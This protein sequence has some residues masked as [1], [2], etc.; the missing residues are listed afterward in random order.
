MAAA[1]FHLEYAWRSRVWYSQLLVG[2][3]PAYGI[4]NGSVAF[5]PAINDKLTVQVYG[6]NLLAKK[7]YD[8]VL[9]LSTTA[10]GV[11]IGVQAAPR[12]YGVSINYDF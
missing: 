5:H 1:D 10:I 12:M 9:D 11:A 8:R 3:Q 7:Y 4:V 6:R 2:S